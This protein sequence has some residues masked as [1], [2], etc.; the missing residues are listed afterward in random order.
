MFFV[1]FFFFSS[2]RRHT[3]CLSDWSSDVCSS[4]LCHAGLTG[5]PRAVPSSIASPGPGVVRDEQ[6][7]G[8]PTEAGAGPRES[9]RFVAGVPGALEQRL[10]GMHPVAA[11]MSAAVGGYVIVCIAFASIG[12]LITHEFGALTRWDDDVARWF[13]ENRSGL[14]NTW[15]N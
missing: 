15:T 12:L 1:F 14:N 2:R 4:D 13:S 8:G 7:M 3:R 6:V 9:V 11:V 5:R 10:S